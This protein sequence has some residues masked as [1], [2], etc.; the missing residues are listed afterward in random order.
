MTSIPARGR[1]HPIGVV[2]EARRLREGEWSPDEI[3]R[4]F[5]QRGVLVSAR[6][7]RRWTDPAVERADRL[8]DLR[9]SRAKAAARSGRLGRSDATPEFRLARMRALRGL[10]MSCGSI[11]TVMNF[12]FGSGLSEHQVRWALETGRY[13]KRA[14]RAAA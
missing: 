2:L 3:A 13:P 10:G 7:V 8:S 9:Q 6:S 4:L 1:R 14:A 12:D 11:A 5:S